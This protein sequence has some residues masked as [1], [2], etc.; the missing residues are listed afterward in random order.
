MAAKQTTQIL[1]RLRTLMKDNSFIAGPIQAY[2]VPSG[3]AHQVCYTLQF[4]FFLVTCKLIVLLRDI[5][6]VMI[7]LR[8][9]PI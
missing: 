9:R 3:D 8:R 1:K 5:F 6:N 7:R 2:I 4:Q